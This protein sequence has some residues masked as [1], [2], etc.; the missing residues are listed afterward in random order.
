MELVQIE[1]ISLLYWLT[2]TGKD[3]NEIKKDLIFIPKQNDKTSGPPIIVDVFDVETG[4]PLS[5]NYFG[6][7][8]NEF[9]QYFKPDVL[10]TFKYKITKEREPT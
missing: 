1:N 4:K 10:K 7:F 2:S 5:D 6:L 9:S 3:I 8:P